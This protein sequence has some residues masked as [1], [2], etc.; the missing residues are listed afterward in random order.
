[1]KVEKDP[2]CAPARTIPAVCE[3]RVVLETVRELPDGMVRMA[4]VV[5]LLK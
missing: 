3:T 2:A 1:L 4:F 5:A